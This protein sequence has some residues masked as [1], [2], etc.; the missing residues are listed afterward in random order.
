[1]SD[2]G[3]DFNDKDA[4]KKIL[5]MLDSKLVSMYAKEFNIGVM[6]DDEVKD[7]FN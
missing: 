7:L 1:M 3:G 5:K 2:D 4:D 6:T